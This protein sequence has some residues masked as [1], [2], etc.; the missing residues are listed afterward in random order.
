MTHRP[1]HAALVAGTLAFYGA[2]LCTAAEQTSSS[3]AVIAGPDGALE[4]VIV[5]ATR[6]GETSLQ[7]TPL[8]VSVFSSDELSA[9]HTSNI[10]ELAQLTPS[11][12]VGVVTASPSIYIRGIGTNNVFNGSDPDV[13]MQIDGVYIARPFAQFTDFFDVERIEVLRGPQGTIYGRNA[14]GGVVNVISKRPSDS[15]VGSLQ[16][17]A[18][19]YD[20]FEARLYASGPVVAG[21]LNLSLAANHVEH[22]AYDD[23]LVPDAHGVGD[24]NTSGARFQALWTPTS[25]ISATTRID[26]SESDEDMQSYD[27]LLVQAPIPVDLANST[28]GDYHTVALDA[29]GG[30]EADGWGVAEDITFSLSDNL[31]LRSLTAYREGSYEL[32][33]DF[34]A[35][36][37]PAAILFQSEDSSQFS[38]EFNLAGT[39]GDLEFVA[40]LY[41]LKERQESF[42]EAIGFVPGDE[43]Y[44][45]TA[46]DLTAESAAAFVQGTYHLPNGVG[47]TLGGRYT[48][49]KKRLDQTFT[50]YDFDGT[51]V[52][53]PLFVFKADV[54]PDFSAF[55]PKVGIDWQIN[56]LIG[57]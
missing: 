1:R 2:T 33:L 40:G 54:S 22:G 16:L 6:T 18:G 21:V 52:G 5:T 17:A 57:A 7:R 13:T 9:T 27:H 14:V 44:F 8:A 43:V 37:F 48:K 15:L 10:A 47:I 45:V 53:P 39:Y 42:N 36:E 3:A 23:N 20:A 26:Y 55:T 19:D 56:E 49:D 11:L 4:E 29:P 41:Y 34:D 51:E 38:Q 32:N 46:P 24:A 35:T 50:V 31:S 12:N 25:S 30:K 28:V